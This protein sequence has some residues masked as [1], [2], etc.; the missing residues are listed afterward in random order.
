MKILKTNVAA[1]SVVGILLIVSTLTISMTALTQ[2]AYGQTDSAAG[3]AGSSPQI[4]GNIRAIVINGNSNIRT[5]AIQGVIRQKIGDPYNTNSVEADRQAIQDMGYFSAVTAHEEQGPGPNDV[6]ITYFVIENPRVAR[7][8]FTGNKVEPTSKLLAV[9]QTKEGQVLNTSTLSRDIQSI[10]GVYQDAGYRASI[11]EEINIDPTTGNLNIPVIEAVVSSITVTGNRKTHAYVIT[12][13]LKTRVGQPYNEIQFRKD[14][15]RVFNLSLF[16]SV[17]PADIS[18][19]DVGK[20]ALSIPV[21]ERQTGTVSVGVGYS[22]QEKLVGRAELAETNFR[23]RGET[24]SVSWEVAGVDS[25][26]SVE[27]AFGDPFI[28]KRHDGFNIDLYNKAIYRFSTSFVSGSGNGSTNQ[29]YE[30]HKGGLLTLSRPI[31]DNSTT[32]ITGRSETVRSNNVA[33]PVGDS[34]IRQDADVSG[35]GLRLVNDTKDNEFNPAAGGYASISIEGV[36]SSESTV[37]NAPTPLPPGRHNFPKFGADL[38][39][40]ISLQGPRRKSITEPKRTLAFRVLL[41]VTATN[42]PFSE[43]YFLGGADSLRGYPDDRFWGNNLF[44]LNS[45]LRI[46]VGGSV[47]GVLFNDIGDA[48]GSIYQGSGLEQHSTISP[49]DAVG[50]G[51]YVTTPIGPIRIDYGY[52]REGGRTDFSIG[53]SF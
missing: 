2:A 41:G 48:W 7:I 18:T 4:Q 52:G 46:P 15:T 23:G 20:V 31:S 28:D 53:Q 6:T 40:Y 11:S 9:M 38:R 50:V 27:L 42:T 13:E 43:Q 35:L 14:L 49:N 26:S 5:E 32:Y 3:G 34:F 1:S 24:A 10:V 22:T 39:R 12:R 36:T 30:R 44:L 16:D 47:T 21:K 51:I 8:I 19:P 25:Q 17:G 33:I 29:Y 45:E 37:G